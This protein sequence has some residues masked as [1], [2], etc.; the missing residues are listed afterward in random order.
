MTGMD[1][2]IISTVRPSPILFLSSKVLIYLF[3]EFSACKALFV[4]FR[5]RDNR[6][7]NHDH[8]YIYRDLPRNLL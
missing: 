4:I 6:I 5:M 3:K 2:L 1:H 7:E 8:R